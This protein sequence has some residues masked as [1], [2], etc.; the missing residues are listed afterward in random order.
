MGKRVGGGS[1]LEGWDV[2]GRWGRDLGLRTHSYY[3]RLVHF[4]KRNV[5][6]LLALGYAPSLGLDWDRCGRLR[7]QSP[8]KTRYK[9]RN[10]GHPAP[11]GDDLPAF[12]FKPSLLK[13]GRQAQRETA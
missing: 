6:R 7:K 11:G 10:P 8:P 9:D 1:E 3:N 5:S 13:A 4:V 12:H 2:G